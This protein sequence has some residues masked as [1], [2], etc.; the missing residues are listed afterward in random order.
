M[1]ILKIGD[2]KKT[3][4]TE[5]DHDRSTDNKQKKR[6]KRPCTQNNN[7]PTNTGI[8]DRPHTQ[9]SQHLQNRACIQHTDRHTY[10]DQHAETLT[11]IHRQT[12]MESRADTIMQTRTPP[13]QKSRDGQ[14]TTQRPAGIEERI[15][16]EM[17]FDG[18]VQD[19]ETQKQR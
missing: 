19:G 1:E 17:R 2:I 12:N 6:Q 3:Q 13:T 16:T 7:R 8:E 14:T 5:T 15:E 9:R 4:M 10:M 18:Y 11:C